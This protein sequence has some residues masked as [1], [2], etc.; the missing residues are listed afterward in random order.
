MALDIYDTAVLNRTVASLKRAQAALLT[1]FFPEI[2]ISDSEKIYFDQ[3]TIKRRIA[4]FVHPTLAGK[5]VQDQGY[6]T[7]NFEPAYIKDKRVFKPDQALRRLAGETIGGNRSP[8]DRAAANL[9]ISLADQQN[10]ILR[11]QEVMVS[12]C[13]RTGIITVTG[14]GYPAVAVNFGR[15]AGH[16]VTLLTTARWGQTGVVPLDNIGTWSRL[17]HKNSGSIVTDCIMDALAFDL[18]IAEAKTQAQLDIRRASQS[19]VQVLAMNKL[20]LAFQGTI[21]QINYWTYQDWYV[22]DAGSEVSMIPDY[23]V[24]LLS[25]DLMGVRHYGAIRD[26]DAGVMAME[27]FSKSWIEPD[28]SVRWLLTQTAPLPVPYRVDASF[29]AT[30]N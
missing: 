17:V 12:E 1:T 2:V 24:M 26:V 7:K 25:T 19:D 28:P 8:V 4:P 22:N 6:V 21:G 9:A 27:S 11:R 29:C 14:D 3:E 16:T 15:D 13:L 10:M 5:V 20:G 23:T 30:V 18:F